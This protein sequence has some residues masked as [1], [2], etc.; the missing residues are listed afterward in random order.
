MASE[1]GSSPVEQPALHA[2][3]RRGLFPSAASAAHRGRISES[4]KLEL[5][6]LPEEPGL[7]GGDQIEHPDPLRLVRLDSSEVLAERR[8]AELAQ[9]ATEASREERL[10]P[11]KALL[12]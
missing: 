9:P 10:L 11:R 5:L 8:Q 4:S 1:Y 7:V 6:A 2:R 12:T 3:M